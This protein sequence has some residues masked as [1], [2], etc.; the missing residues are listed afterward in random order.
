M[1]E[2]NNISLFEKLKKIRISKKIKLEEFAAQS[3][4]QIKYLEAIELGELDK[5]PAVYD[6]LFFNAYLNF[7]KLSPEETDHFL[8]EFSALR[9]DTEK[10]YD[11]DLYKTVSAQKS[12]LSANLLKKIYIAAPILVVFI[13]ILVMVFYSTGINDNKSEIKEINV[14]EIAD[15]LE[16]E[17]EN[18]APESKKT[19]PPPTEDSLQCA[20][21]ISALEKTWLRIVKDDTDTSEYMLNPKNRLSFE[22][23]E[24][25][26]FLIGNAAGVEFNVNG[27]NEGK[28]GAEG[29]VISYLLITR[30]GIISKKTKKP[31]ANKNTRGSINDTTHT[32]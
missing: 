7:L 21:Q 8:A 14:V 32:D 23:K 30:E 4:I 31:T 1:D 5:I 13:V 15:S 2:L 27:K 18:L 17:I 22:A 11:A 24:K 28:L 26:E 16:K 29:E 10:T 25:M 19:T 3:Q 20:V 9:K 6:K 12:G